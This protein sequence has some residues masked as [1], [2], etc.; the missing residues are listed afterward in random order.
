MTKGDINNVTVL[1]GGEGYKVG[2]L[3]VFDN[4]G[5]NGSGFSAKVDE[6]VGIGVS[7]IDTTL[8]KF[9]NAVFTWKDNNNVTANLLPFFE[10]NDQTSISVSGLNTSI[11]NLTG[12]F[13]VGVSTDTIGLAKTMAVGNA[14]GVIEDIYVSDIPNTVSVGG[15]LRVGSESCKGIKCL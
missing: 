4:A 10:L 6:L 7:R 12:S 14:N 9:E 1:D 5:T 11:V 15:S 8:D 3:T 2:D 13:K